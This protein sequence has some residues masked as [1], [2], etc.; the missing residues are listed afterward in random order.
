VIER[1]ISTAL[2]I[3]DDVDW[4]PRIREQLEAFGRASRNLPHMIKRADLAAQNIIL[5]QGHTSQRDSDQ[6]PIE[7]AKRSTLILSAV[8]HAPSS[9]PSSDDND[10]DVLWLGH[11]GT[12][13]PPQRNGSAHDEPPD[14]YML[15]DDATV[16]DSHSTQSST[17]PP[18]TRI[19][20]CSH[21]TRCILAYAVTQ[22]GARKIMYEHGIRNFDKDY[23]SALSEWCD[24]LTKH[25]GD[26][27]MCLTSSPSIFGNFTL[28]RDGEES[29]SD[30][31]GGS[32]LIKSV[33]EGLG[34]GIDGEKL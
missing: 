6:D 21:A 15:L 30:G 17:Y 9:S 5:S 24:G 27:P 33:R 22:R 16:S 26:R 11:C 13:L 8:S 28:H 12:S 7:L 1:N 31:S 2:I 32:S 20:H 3:E 4:D 34:E 23:G 18:R 10:W 14:R 29:V 19:Y 25:M